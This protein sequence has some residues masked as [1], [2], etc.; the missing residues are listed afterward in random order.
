M[1]HLNFQTINFLSH[2]SDC[3]TLSVVF[4]HLHLHLK[5]SIFSGSI[6][7]CSAPHNS[8]GGM[9]PTKDNDRHRNRTNLIMPV[10]EKQL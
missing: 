10:P 6:K 9:L 2:L 5:E 7:R 1:N 8:F 3:T 4:S